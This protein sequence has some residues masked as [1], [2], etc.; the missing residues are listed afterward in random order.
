VGVLI[1]DSCEYQIAWASS[2]NARGYPQAGR[3]VEYEFVV[4]VAELLHEDMPGDDDLCRAVGAYAAYR[5]QSVFEQAVI[6]LDRVVRVLPH[7]MPGAEP[8]ALLR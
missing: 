3:Y 7:V 4:A 5:P 6:G 8:A 2:V 1:S